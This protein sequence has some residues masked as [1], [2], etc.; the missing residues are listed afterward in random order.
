MDGQQTAMEEKKNLK[1]V[2]KSIDGNTAAA[3]IAYACS[4][5]AAIY[6]ITPSTAMGEICDEWAAHGRKNIFGQI[7]KIAEMQSEGGA[8]GA[9]HGALS[10]G[11][12][13]TTFT[14]SQG[15]LLMIPNM[16]KIAGELM[17][18]VFHVT[19]RAIAAQALSIFG[20]HQ[21][22]MET[23]ATGFC[24]LCSNSV[25]E[26][27]DLALV[28]HLSSLRASL[29]F[30]HF[31]DGFRTSHEIQKIEM[32]NYDDV[33]RLVDMGC[34]KHHRE[35]A[36]NP[37]HP[38]LRGS[39]QNPDIYFQ[40]NEAANKY[41]QAVP[42]IVEEEMKKV[43]DLTGRPYHLFEYVG[44]TDADRII[45]QMGSGCEATEETVQYLL[46]NGEKVGLLKVRLFRPFSAEHFLFVLPKSVKKIAV[47]DRTKESTAFGEPLYLDISTVIHDASLNMLIVGG[48]YG[49][50][51]KEFTPR[52]AKAV[53]DNL[54][55]DKPRNHFTIGIEDDVT[56]LSLP[57]GE[58]I[59]V[60]PPGVIRCRFWG[61]GSDG[62]VGA[63]KDAIK[64]IGDNTDLYVQGYFAYDS[65]KSGGVSISNLRFGKT[66]IHS[67]Y[68]IDT[69]DYIACHQSSYIYKYDVLEGIREGGMF[70]Y[71]APWTGEQ[72]EKRLPNSLKKT[73]AQKKL[74][75]YVIDAVKIAED[76]G[77]GG[78][79]NMVMQTVFFKLSNVLPFDDAVRLLKDAI[80]KTYDK[81]GKTIIEMNWKAV[82]CSLESVQEVHYPDSW[83]NL[84]DDP[85]EVRDEPLFIQKVMRPMLAQ[86]GDKLPVSVFIPGGM[87]PVG[88]SQYE[89]RGVAINV[90]MW[91]MDNCIQCNQCSMV[92]P[93][94]AIR[95]VLVAK[96]ELK[97]VPAGFDVKH[98]VGKD[99]KDFYFH[100]QVFSEDC[101]G[102]GNCADICPAK[103]KAL[104]MK[105]LASQMEKQIPFQRFTVTLPTR[106]GHF[107]SF[108]A[109]ESQFQ[110]PLLE[111]SGACAGCGE[112]PY[113][114]LVTQLYGD[115][116]IIANAT[117]CS[118]IWGG[119]APC[120][121]YTTNEKGHGPAWANSLFEDNAEY[122]FGMVLATMQRRARLVDLL[123]QAV[124]ENKVSGKLKDACSAWLE[125]MNDVEKSR[126]YGDMIKTLLKDASKDQL[127]QQIWDACDLLTKKSIWAVGGDGWAYDIGYGGLDHVLACGED[128]NVLVFDTE[129][130][131][132][133]G[134]QSSKATP[135]GSIAKFAESG[136]KTKKKDL[137]LIAMS[138]GY[139]YVASVAMGANKSQMMKALKEAESYPGPSL[140]IAYAPCINHGIKAGMGKSQNEERLAVDAGY[141]S[142]YR[143]DPR[144][145]LDGKNPFQL[146][147]IEPNG[148]IR[149]FLMGEIRYAALTKSFPQEAEKLHRKLGDEIADRY[150]RYKNMAEP[151]EN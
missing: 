56:F 38:H 68:L 19:G 14:A 96:D 128:I 40:V 49:L 64:I 58:S 36:L 118:S 65:K 127:L 93:H 76:V 43:S 80:K 114:K 77:L 59:D 98:A 88:T 2:M 28:A 73:I 26:V 123:K 150:K 29:P 7:L 15:L 125:H 148:K 134:G 71:N 41:Y 113:L 121:P 129:V 61:M 79:I 47:L 122:G 51:S 4:D 104:V 5:V 63:N 146:D 105:P 34:V 141:W 6:P 44:A 108:S 55:Q 132:N 57:L 137:G 12:L 32:I 119:S 92:C 86:Q 135:M 94:A 139:V 42:K 99:L 131:S 87:L 142:L 136:K 90:P 130:Y 85:K 107:N 124:A 22:V 8:A 100:I 62:T 27:M 83:R 143:Y 103:E 133:T 35:R 25:Q 37:E 48:R 149:E 17:P 106:I 140:V 84:E 67:T 54:K 95:P 97:N 120:V 45:I 102:C 151:G 39:A 101:M 53:F 30:M 112:T 66:P 10:A 20:D 138:Y 52:M 46:K 13:A 11:A 109:K 91:L 115:R 21:D 74:R 60:S 1:S 75:F 117:G 81:K 78:R 147:S 23:R 110:R 18:C 111:F 70:V 89:K 116:L 9:V 31:F 69:A 145:V 82:D 126:L 72:L 33:A 16:Y 24:L 144:L 50:G 3:H